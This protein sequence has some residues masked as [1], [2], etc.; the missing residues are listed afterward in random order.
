M[1]LLGHTP[2]IEVFSTV[3]IGI[4]GY[5][6]I[7]VVRNIL[8]CVFH[9]SRA[10]NEQFFIVVHLLLFVSYGLFVASGRLPF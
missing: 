4:T 6:Y 7:I 8:A 3:W 5:L 1:K 9:L 10:L 2:F